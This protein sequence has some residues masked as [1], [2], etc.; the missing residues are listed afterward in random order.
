MNKLSM[1]CLMVGALALPM[2][3]L[4]DDDGA[5]PND[6]KMNTT[7][8]NLGKRPDPMD[9]RATGSTVKPDATMKRDERRAGNE[10]PMDST[11]NTSKGSSTGNA[12]NALDNKETA[13]KENRERGNSEKTD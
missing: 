13:P 2:A 11:R 3:V 4:A 8:P 6:G 1:T 5:G 9:S 7:N 10:R 12:K